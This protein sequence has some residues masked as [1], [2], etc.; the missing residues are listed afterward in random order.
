MT[1][2]SSPPFASCCTTEKEPSKGC[3]SHI[4]IKLRRWNIVGMSV[5]ELNPLLQ[6]PG[7]TPHSLGHRPVLHF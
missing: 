3:H 5:A 6:T 2:F 1:V 4:A 7:F